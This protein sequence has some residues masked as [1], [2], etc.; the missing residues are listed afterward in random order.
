MLPE[1]SEY[2]KSIYSEKIIRLFLKKFIQTEDQNQCW[3]W[4]AAK[5]KDGY[6]IYVVFSHGRNFLAHR[7]AYELFIGKIPEGRQIVH[8]CGDKSCMN[9]KHLCLKIEIEKIFDDKNV[10]K[11]TNNN[12]LD[13]ILD[14]G[15]ENPLILSKE[16]EKLN[17]DTS[18]NFL[19]KGIIDKRKEEHCLKKVEYNR[20]GWDI[21][22]KLTA[23]EKEDIIKRRKSGESYKSIAD[24]IERD[25]TTI[26][27]ICKFWI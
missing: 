4:L 18:L 7:F 21:R 24:S 20:S 6:G 22:P 27:K 16:E 17:N 10:I 13:L 3:P 14:S 25:Y 12:I 8:I 15:L 2:S 23:T 26:R 5:N 1:L 19:V 9:Y 11:E